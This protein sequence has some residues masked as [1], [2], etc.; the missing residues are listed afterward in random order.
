MFYTPVRYPFREFLGRFN[1]NRMFSLHSVL[2]Y[3]LAT[4]FWVSYQ[5]HWKLKVKQT[6]NN[7]YLIF[8]AILTVTIP[9]VNTVQQS[10]NEIV[11]L[12][13]I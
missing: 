8:V 5:R 13:L 3:L 12:W 4:K 1:F 7:F 6:D 9:C 11:V 2:E 10:V